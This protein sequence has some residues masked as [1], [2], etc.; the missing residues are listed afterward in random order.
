MARTVKHPNVFLLPAYYTLPR[1][2][3]GTKGEF[4]NIPR[5]PRDA[6]AN[7]ESL[8]KI[9]SKRF[10]LFMDDMVAN[11]V[12]PYI[13]RRGWIESYSGDSRHMPM[14]ICSIT[15]TTSCIHSLKGIWILRRLFQRTNPSNGVPWRNPVK[16]GRTVWSLRTGISHI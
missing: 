16:Y 10:L 1:E 2:A 4:S 6:L 13:G 7:P 14:P 3:V 15:G 12:W 5:N 8:E 9:T 11:M